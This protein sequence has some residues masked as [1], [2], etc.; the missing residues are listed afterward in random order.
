VVPGDWNVTGTTD[1]QNTTLD[2][3][4]GGMW[5]HNYTGTTFPFVSADVYYTLFFTNVTNINGFGSEGIGFELNS[6]LTTQVNGLYQATYM[7]I[8]SGQNNHIYLTTIFVND[9]NKENCGNHHKMA[10]GGDVITQSGNCFI[11][12]AVGDKVSLRT[13]DLGGE[14]DGVYYGGNLNLVRVG[15]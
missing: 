1:L 2:N 10:S 3:Y 5:Y 6:N 9:E 7:A 12:L 4:Y 11:R 13:A 8:G 14:G 15:D